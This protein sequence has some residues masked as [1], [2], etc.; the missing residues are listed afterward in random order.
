MSKKHSEG[1]A[2]LYKTIPGSQENWS[3]FTSVKS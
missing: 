3:Y 1:P 2:I